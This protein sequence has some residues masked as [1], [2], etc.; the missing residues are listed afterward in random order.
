[1]SPKPDV[2]QE[3]ISQ[4]I[5]A[6]IQVFARKG[7]HTARMEDIAIEAGLS[8]ATLYLYF[9]SKDELA[10]TIIR[11]FYHRA[12]Q[13]D[14]SSFL[15]NDSVSTKLMTIFKQVSQN[16]M[17]LNPMVPIT[18]EFLSEATRKEQIREYIQQYYEKNTTSMANLIQEGIDSGEF[19]QVDPQSTA[20]ILGATFEGL[21]LMQTI[22]PTLIDWSTMPTQVLSTFLK[23]ICMQ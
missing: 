1:M 23:G 19:Q 12:F 13:N 2:R 18:F 10:V 11:E 7:I 6:A 16:L 22:H 21:L 9:K 20:L 4:I 5:R 8:K 17:Q 15:D 14:S 3:R